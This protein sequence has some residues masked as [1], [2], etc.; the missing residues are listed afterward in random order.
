MAGN[1]LMIEGIDVYDAV[2]RGYSEF[3]NA[4]GT[5]IE[6]YFANIDTDAV[7]GHSANIKG[8]L[9]EQQ[10]VDALEQQGVAAQMF[11]ATNHPATDIYIDDGWL[12]TTEFQL[13]ATDSTSYIQAT[14]E[15]YDSIPIIATHEVAAQMQNDLVIDAGITNEAL[16]QVVYETLFAEQ[17]ELAS[18]IAVTTSELT[19]DTVNEGLAELVTDMAFPISPIGAILALLG[20]PFA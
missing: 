13:K 19:Q 7:V 15:Q 10:V 6:N 3:Q 20:L 1:K 12:G 9:F 8:I 11:T 4:S 5:D 14:L 16:N 18:T 17:M 2:R